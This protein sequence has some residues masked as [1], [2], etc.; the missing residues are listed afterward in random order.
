MALAFKQPRKSYVFASRENRENLT[1]NQLNF[2]E[3]I[4]L[5]N[6]NLQILLTSILQVLDDVRPEKVKALNE[7]SKNSE[8]MTKLLEEMEAFFEFL[9]STPLVCSPENFIPVEVLLIDSRNFQE[10]IDTLTLSGI[11]GLINLTSKIRKEL[12]KEK[13]VFQEPSVAE[14]KASTLGSAKL[15]QISASSSS[16]VFISKSS[17]KTKTKKV[18][19]AEFK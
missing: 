1:K 16:A 15:G 8:K 5:I 7:I 12:E 9:K 19:D 18:R 14:S 17:G 2:E 10:G 13:F 4:L 6:I 3:T 11:N